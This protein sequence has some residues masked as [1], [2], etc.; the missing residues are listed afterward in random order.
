MLIVC[1]SCASEYTIDPE[2]FGADGRTVR[3][4]ICRDI[5]FVPGQADGAEAAEPAMAGYAPEPAPTAFPPP[6]RAPGRAGAGGRLV[7]L[8]S[9]L[10]VFAAC[11]GWQHSEALQALQGRWAAKVVPA[12]QTLSQAALAAWFGPPARPEFRGVR[13]VLIDQEGG[14]VLV[15]SGEIANPAVEEIDVPHLEILVRNGE[16]QV[17]ASWTDV[18]PQRTL[19]PGASVR[20]STR[21]SS[22]PHAGREVRVQFT[23]GGI[24]VAARSPGHLTDVR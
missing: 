13:S 10:L 15:V 20:F 11:L 3:C 5:W 9:G 7:A 14:A 23:A 8:A 1:P 22:P 21:L 17:L 24:A 4:A 18:P 12:F 16:E 2:K 19:G 6:G